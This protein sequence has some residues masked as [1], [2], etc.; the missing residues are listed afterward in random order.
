MKAGHSFGWT[1]LSSLAVLSGIIALLSL[2][3]VNE[4]READKQAQSEVETLSRVLEAHT[5]A[6]VQ[7]VDLVL[8]D[9]QSHVNPDDMRLTHGSGDSRSR[10]YHALLKSHV[11]N[12]QEVSLLHLIN[13]N[14][15]HIYSSLATL[16]SVNLADRPYFQRHRDDTATGLM[17]SAPIIS[18]VTGNWTLILSRR[19]NFADGNFAGTVQA[20]LDMKYFQ[21]FYRSLNLNQHAMV[22]LYDK[23]LS[24][25][26]RYPPSETDMGKI[27]NL[28]A[29]I[30]VDKG[31]THA[32]Y[33]A[34]SP[35][36]SVNRK[37]S[38]RQAGDLPLYVFA[39]VAEDGYLAE[40]R[41]HAWEY[42][43]GLIVFSMVLIGLGQR[44]RRAEDALLKSED[45]F[46]SALEHAPIGMALASPD[47]K[48]VQVNR[49]FCD[50]VGYAPEALLNLSFE[51]IT[52]PDDV[53]KD[54]AYLKR[55]ETG[56][57]GS[58]EIEKRYLHKDGRI[59]WVQNT[60]SIARDETGTQQQI[61]QQ[62]QDITERKE[63]AQRLEHEARTDCLTGLSNRR[64]FLELASQELVRVRRY[65]SPLTLAMLDVDHFK[66]IN[67]TYGHEIGDKVLMELA[68]ICCRA[69]REPDVV[70]RIGG[71][72]FAILFPQTTGDQAYEIAE[73]LRVAIAAAKVP[74]ERGLPVHFTVSLGI[75]SFAESDTNIDMLLSRADKALYEAKHKGRNRVVI[76]DTPKE[77]PG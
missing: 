34:N 58:Y 29:G 55:M 54:I 18:R 67:D 39:G 1:R 31:L 37:Y 10:K 35:L 14:G 52:H 21:K 5:L 36:D 2:S 43:F 72:E 7:Q 8:N 30:F 16:P 61:I 40:W 59:V 4:Y 32:S 75:T 65:R 74:I 6:I 3:L 71:E 12:V 15:E 70:G 38:F 48:F 60:V 46:R 28:E 42:G 76:E 20:S 47:G 57:I 33:H 25:A 22:A 45:R 73:R 17:I 62:V 77:K 41:Q 63:P 13:K 68:D 19:I 26:A 69:L 66:T 53:A 49:A 24:L 50:I 9:V 64:H 44:Q 27:S 51:A 23:H 11:E 56:E